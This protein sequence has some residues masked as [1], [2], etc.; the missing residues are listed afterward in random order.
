MQALEGE[1]A[2]VRAL[3]ATIRADPRH[4]HVHL[5]VTLSVAKRQF[6]QWSMGFKNLDE[7]DVSTVPGYTPYPDFPP[8]YERASW[9]SSIS[10][11]MLASFIQE[12]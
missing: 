12:Y 4:D 5:L 10:M 6:P 8:P 1:E 11:S 7:I 3:F 2:T 9:K